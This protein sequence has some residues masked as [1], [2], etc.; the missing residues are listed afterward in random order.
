MQMQ[1]LLLHDCD[2]GNGDCTFPGGFCLEEK[3]P[4]NAIRELAHVTGM[5]SIVSPLPEE[6]EGLNG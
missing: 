5:C 3:S 1:L 2:C 6:Q 4:T